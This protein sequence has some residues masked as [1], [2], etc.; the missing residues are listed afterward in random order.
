[1]RL[2]SVLSSAFA[3]PLLAQDAPAALPFPG[4]LKKAEREGGNPLA[5]YAAMLELD[6][7]YRSSAQLSAVY[8]EVRCNYEQF[9]GVPEAGPEAMALPALR[10]PQ[11]AGEQPVPEGFAP[12]PA[13][14]AIAR[15]AAKTRLVIF[16]EEHHLRQTRSLYEA[17]LRRLWECGYRWLAAETFAPEVMADGFRIP[18]YHSGYYTMD[19]VFASA[20]RT[21]RQ[22]GWRL[23]AYDTSERGPAGDGSF[24]DRTQ[25]QNLK[26]LVFDRDPEA[27]LLVFCGRGHAAEVPPKDGWTPM[28]SVLKQPTGIDPFTI[29][30]PTMSERRTREE[31]D[32]MYRYATAH[33]LVREPVLFTDGSERC[34]GSGNC[35][36][37]LF[38][39]RVQL[40][41]GRPDWLAKSMGRAATAIPAALQKGEGLR[42]VQA[43]FSGEPGTA[44]PVDQVLLRP[45]QAG[46]PALML[47]KG[48]FWLRTL[49]PQSTVAGPVDLIVK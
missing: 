44:V 24:R 32:P 28:A 7:R 17:L 27:K 18:D 49:D 16:G 14:A 40:V 25:A 5:T 12:V 19:P 10:S 31:E 47:P 15:E 39:P 48:A 22:L 45:G 4:L 3:L 6:A 33:D 11:P 35:D 38:W 36:S 13:V 2:R 43:F 37:Y 21:A 34:V 1:M 8:P 41:D 30:A 9:L 23:V 29:F 46:A 20:V 26:R 42:L